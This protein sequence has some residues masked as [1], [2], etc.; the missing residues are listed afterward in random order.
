MPRKPGPLG[1]ER[2][3][4]SVD[5]RKL[6]R[7]HGG[8]NKHRSRNCIRQASCSPTH[9]RLSSQDHTQSVPLSRLHNPAKTVV[10]NPARQPRC[11]RLSVWRVSPAGST[12]P[13]VNF[14]S[15]VTSQRPPSHKPGG[16]HSTPTTLGP[17]KKP[18]GFTRHVRIAHQS[19]NTSP[20]LHHR[21]GTCS[22]RRRS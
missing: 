12:R 5:H 21:A 6:R 13:L 2:V 11:S 4:P 17:R 3:E 9:T 16:E 8:I 7:T 19:R 18:S 22:C 20:R 10:S 1:P 15:L 14:A